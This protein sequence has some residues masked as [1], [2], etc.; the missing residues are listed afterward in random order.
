MVDMFGNRSSRRS[1]QFMVHV[2]LY[3]CSPSLYF[4]QSYFFFVGFPSTGIVI[5][6]TV[7]WKSNGKAGKLFAV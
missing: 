5:L 4:F 3:C 6:W 2:N 7:H 1:A